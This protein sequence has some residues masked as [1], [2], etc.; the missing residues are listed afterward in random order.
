MIPL[1]DGDVLRYEIGHKC[2][3]DLGPLHFDKVAECIDNDIAAICRGAGADE[4]P[5]I[6]LTGKE[7]FRDGI[8][9]SKP[10]KGNRKSEK[11]FHWEN[12]TAYLWN[13]YEVRLVEGLEADD[14][15]AIEQVGWMGSDQETIICTRD[16]DLRMVPGWHYGWECGAQ[17]E[18]GP[19]FADIIGD[20]ELDR[21]KKPPKLSGYGLKFFYAQLLMGDSVD[22]IP[23]LPRCGAVKAYDVLHDADT[24]AVMFERVRTEYEM[25]GYGDD[26]LL[27]QGQLLWMTQELT[28]EGKPKLWQ[29]PE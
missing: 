7:N 14:L 4:A 16:K 10:Y 3:G 12:I 1:I 17:R 28:E 8:A 15:M 23:G 9:V 5:V 2:Q 11:P 18:F 21:E 20:I 26:Y 29:F 13:Q 19:L 24:E 25:K 27:E 22:N 6:F